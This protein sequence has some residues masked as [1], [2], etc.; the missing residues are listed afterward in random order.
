MGNEKSPG[1]TIS[2]AE[3][4]DDV[5]A[6]KSLFQEYAAFLGVDLCFQDFDREMETFPAFYRCLLFGR[7]GDAGAGAVGLK[8][9]GEG[10]C[11]MKRLYVRPDFHGKGLG[12][13]LAVALI[14]EARRR[15]YARMVLDTLPRLDAAI[16]L[17]RNLGFVDTQKYYDNPE[18]GVLYMALDLT[19]GR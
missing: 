2:L 3:T 6:V 4:R 5:A 16:A 19:D 18:E 12:R 14:N 9:R 17:Y 13:Q 15:G 10:V 8:D 7:I 11:E 1:I